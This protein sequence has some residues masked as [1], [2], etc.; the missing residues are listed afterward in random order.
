MNQEETEDERADRLARVVPALVLADMDRR[1]PIE[2]LNQMQLD[3]RD[4]AGI[5][6]YLVHEL[7]VTI[8]LIAAERGEDPREVVVQKALR[9]AEGP[10]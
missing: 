10:L 3:G 8:R 1:N 7:A 9:L 2:V 5:L 6:A 4:V